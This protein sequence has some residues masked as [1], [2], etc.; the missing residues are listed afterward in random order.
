MTSTNHRRIFEGNDMYISEPKAFVIGDRNKVSGD[1]SIVKGNKNTV[2]G[3]GSTVIGDDNFVWADKSA[4]VGKNNI[5]TGGTAVVKGSSNHVTNHESYII[6]I[7]TFQHCF[8]K[9]DYASATAEWV[10]TTMEGSGILKRESRLRRVT[11]R[12]TGEGE[13][14]EIN[15][16]HSPS[17]PVVVNTNIN[18]IKDLVCTPAS[19]G[20]DEKAC[21]ICKE[22]AADVI[23]MPCGH[24]Q[25]CAACAKRICG[26]RQLVNIRSGMVKCPWCADDVWKF[27]RV[28]S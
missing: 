2:V 4:V 1:G 28:Y 15:P 8:T 7:D 22:H 10:K 3:P 16:V 26:E 27:G 19:E 17:A 18:D 25:F 24:K 13:I 20:E 12:L 23:A 11:I 6:R 5:V 14:Q 9:A 21:I